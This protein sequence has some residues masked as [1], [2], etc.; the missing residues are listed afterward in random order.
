MPPR[1]K[2]Q[3]E[4]IVSAAV[5]IARK[6]GIEA[7]TAREV[8]A[9]LGVST[10]PIFT[11]FETIEQLKGEVYKQAQ[12]YYRSYIRDGLKEKI[13]FLGVG[14]QYIHF[15]KEEPELYKLLFL[16]KSSDS[17]GG[18]ME[19]LELS[20]NLVRESI[21]NIYNMNAYTADCYFRNLWLVAFSMATLIVT[22]DCPY[23]DKE[24]SSIFTE[25]SLAV[26]KAY[27]EI[28]GLAK[29]N[30]DRDAIFKELVRK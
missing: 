30:Y 12:E 1:V 25:M 15:A 10:R 5:N 7:V 13:P 6:K 4:D 29:G 17:L 2:F 20:Q 21:M 28:P 18:A 22:D 9:E 19:A 26:C 24:I 16:T 8:A 11:W 27:K 14:H 23:T 3:K